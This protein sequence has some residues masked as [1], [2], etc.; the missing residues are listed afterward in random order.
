M[1]DASGRLAMDA[2][3][4]QAFATSNDVVVSA[5]SDGSTDPLSGGLSSCLSVWALVVGIIRSNESSGADETT[6][7]KR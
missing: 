7:E 5:T 1:H 2:I 3:L 6:D 4:K